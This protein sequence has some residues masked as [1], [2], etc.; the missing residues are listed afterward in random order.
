VEA[1]ETIV[2][3]GEVLLAGTGCGPST[4]GS[5]FLERSAEMI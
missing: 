3:Q 2:T 4:Y 1:D 5:P